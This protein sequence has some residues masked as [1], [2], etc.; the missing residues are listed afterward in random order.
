MTKLGLTL[1]VAPLKEANTKVEQ[2]IVDRTTAQSAVAA[3]ELRQ[4]RLATDAAYRH[5][6]NTSIVAPTFGAFES[7][8]KGW[9]VGGEYTFAKNIV[10][11]VAYVDGENIADRGTDVKKIWS[12]I[13]YFF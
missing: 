12:R 4:A 8:W 13:K 3:G 7:S 1:F 5:L 6:G 2:F 9:E 11:Y 10:G